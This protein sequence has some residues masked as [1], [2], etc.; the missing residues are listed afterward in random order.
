MYT[1]SYCNAICLYIYIVIQVLNNTVETFGGLLF[2]IPVD[3]NEATDCTC[4]G[5]V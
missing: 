2:A 4:L 1:T 5:H 3:D